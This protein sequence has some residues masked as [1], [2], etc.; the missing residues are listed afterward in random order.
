MMEDLIML[1]LTNDVQSLAER[2]KFNGNY[3]AYYNAPLNTKAIS[4][5][6]KLLQQY[7]GNYHQNHTIDKP[8]L[9]D[10]LCLPDGQMVYFCYIHN[11]SAQTCGGGSFHLT[12]DGYISYSGGLDHG[13]LLS[14][15]ELTTQKYVLPVW[16]CHRGYLTGGC[17]IYAHI[18]CRVWTTKPGADLSGVPQVQRLRRQKLKAQSETITKKDSNGREYEEHLPEIMIKKNNLSDELFQE[19]LRITG[20]QFEDSQ[21]C[22]PVYWCQPMKLTQIETLKSFVQLRWSVE[23]HY[24]NYNPLLVFQVK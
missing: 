14:E 4:E 8:S 3:R 20:L 21:Y 7:A 12:S 19:V 23:K 22:V 13:L 6:F 17:G 16:F 2:N 15:I 18:E 11:I 24:S 10:A 5:D 9:G 1:E